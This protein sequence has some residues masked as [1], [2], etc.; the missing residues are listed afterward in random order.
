MPNES[1]NRGPDK[2]E[3]YLNECYHKRNKKILLNRYFFKYNNVHVRLHKNIIC[4]IL[5][6]I[7]VVCLWYPIK[8]L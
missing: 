1:L 8:T 2:S 5:P 4:M 7:F 6:Q 3:F